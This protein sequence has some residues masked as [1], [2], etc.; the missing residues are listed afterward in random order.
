MID[1]LATTGGTL[2]PDVDFGAIKPKP[3]TAKVNW[4]SVTNNADTRVRIIVP[5][6]YYS[7]YPSA[8]GFKG[9]LEE[10]KG[11]I[12]PYTPTITYNQTANYSPQNLMHAN[13]N[14]YFYQRSDVGQ[15]QIA[16]IFTVQNDLDAGVFLATQHLLRALIK[17]QTGNDLL[18]GAPPPV[19][20]LK[21]YGQFMLDNVP[22]V[23]SN[24]SFNLENEIDYYVLGKSSNYQMYGVNSVPAKTTVTI[25]CN[26]VYSRT[27]MQNF[28]VGGWLDGDL[29]TQ[30][31]L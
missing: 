8:S 14:Q 2:L 3:V 10:I 18:P 19:C 31:Y 28:S 9:E 21:A 16:G 23:I 11:I 29:R 1:N 5:E 27:Q 26:P 20:R 12:F 22:I 17:M 30:G 7:S 25:T 6:Y 24:V 15:I 4:S 13:Y